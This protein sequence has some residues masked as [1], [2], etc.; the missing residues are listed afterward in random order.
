MI[1]DVSAEGFFL[2]PEGPVPP[3]LRNGDTVWVA[4]RVDGKDASLSGVVRWSGAHP[5]YQL[6]GCGIQVEGSSLDLLHRAFPELSR[7]EPGDESGR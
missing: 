1:Y 7:V 6:I 2:V 3:S 5:S 4:V